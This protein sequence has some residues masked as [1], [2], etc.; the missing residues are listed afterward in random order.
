MKRLNE[1][2][3]GLLIV[4][5]LV[6]FHIDSHCQ[7]I[8]V[9]GSDWTVPLTNISEAGKDYTNV[10]ESVSNQILLNG[11]GSAFFWLNTTLHI[12]AH[13][14]ANINWNS[15]L[16]I[17]LKRTGNGSLS[18]GTS[19]SGGTN[20]INLLNGTAQEIFTVHNGCGFCTYTFSNVPIQLQLSGIS[21]TVPVD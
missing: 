1:K 16:I 9:N 5:I 11:S 19:I 4:V 7:S 18:S 10:Q 14:T 13:Y 3:F 12:S 2:L 20:Y 6:G 17:A 21:V 8:T 15:N